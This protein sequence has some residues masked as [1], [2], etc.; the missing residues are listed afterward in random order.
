LGL[1]ICKDIA[2]LYGGTLEFGRSE[3]LGEVSVVVSLPKLL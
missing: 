3:A 2:K 1:S